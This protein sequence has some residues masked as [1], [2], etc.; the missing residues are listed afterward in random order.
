MTPLKRRV[1]TVSA[2]LLLAFSLTACGGGGGSDAPDNASQE[3]FCKAF[4]DTP[5]GEDANAAHDYADKLK[6]VGTPD[7][8]DGDAREGFELY[9]DFL[10]DV[11]DDDIKKFS[12]SSDPSDVFDNKGDL[13]KI[14]AFYTEAFGQCS[15]DLPTDIPS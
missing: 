4:T 2:P 13:E 8:I 14:T 15:P 5:D 11:S 3:E 10:G 7:S 6:D 9:V 12:E 1:A